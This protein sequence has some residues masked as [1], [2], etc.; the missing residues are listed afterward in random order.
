M[1]CYIG[2]GESEPII[3]TS[4]EQY[5]NMMNGFWHD[6]DDLELTLDMLKS[7]MELVPFAVVGHSRGKVLLYRI[8]SP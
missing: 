7:K 2:N 1:F 6:V 5:R 3:G 8:C 4:G